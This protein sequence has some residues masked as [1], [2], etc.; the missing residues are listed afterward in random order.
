[1]RYVLV[2]S[3]FPQ[4][5]PSQAWVLLFLV[6]GFIGMSA[7]VHMY[8]AHVHEISV[9]AVKK[10]ERSLVP[11]CERDVVPQCCMG[12]LVENVCCRTQ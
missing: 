8:G 3:L 10:L 11:K 4:S 5:L 6:R 2:S 7:R 12:C 1:M 9:L